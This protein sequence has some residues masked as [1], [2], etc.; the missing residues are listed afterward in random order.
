MEALEQNIC[1]FLGKR[2]CDVD[3]DRDSG[4]RILERV[5]GRGSNLE[6]EEGE[7]LSSIYLCPRLFLFEYE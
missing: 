4:K 6:K 2:K 7:L 3:V 5:V 1:N